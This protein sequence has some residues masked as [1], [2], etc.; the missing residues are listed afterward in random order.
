MIRSFKDRDTE[1]LH[2]RQQVAKFASFERVARR[3]LAQIDAALSLRDLS[4]PG[5][6]LEKLTKE[7]KGQYAIRINDK[8]RLC[9]VW[10]PDG[11][12]DVEITDYH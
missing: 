2:D 7:R 11:V 8:Y 10:E 12:H 5:N 3:K 4:A 6:K 9:F 1:R